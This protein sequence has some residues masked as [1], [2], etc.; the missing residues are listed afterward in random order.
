MGNIA[1]YGLLGPQSQ[2]KDGALT[3]RRVDRRALSRYPL[4]RSMLRNSSGL[5]TSVAV[6]KR[7]KSCILSFQLSV[8]SLEPGNVCMGVRFVGVLLQGRRHGRRFNGALLESSM[9]TQSGRRCPQV[10]MLRYP[11]AVG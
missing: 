1:E 8:S 3:L 2:R 10:S 4:W 9:T 7:D 6:S 11:I 5:P